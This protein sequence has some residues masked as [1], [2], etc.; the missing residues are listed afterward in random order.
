M[1]AYK[2]LEKSIFYTAERVIFYTHNARSRA[3]VLRAIS[4]DSFLLP[5]SNQKQFHRDSSSCQV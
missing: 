2:I 1:T 5:F 3:E 4:P